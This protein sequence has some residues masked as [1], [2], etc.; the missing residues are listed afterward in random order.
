MKKLLAMILA[1]AMTLT[2][3]TACGKDDSQPDT[4][5]DSSVISGSQQTEPE[6]DTDYNYETLMQIWK[7]DYQ[8]Y[9]ANKDGAYLQ[10]TYDSDNKAV[11]IFYNKEGNPTSYAQA[12]SLMS[13]DKS[14]YR[15]DLYYPEKCEGVR[16]KL[17]QTVGTGIL[18]I[19]RAGEV[20]WVDFPY[21]LLTDSKGNSKAYA[22]AGRDGREIET[23]ME[24]AA[25][26]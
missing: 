9:W 19:E 1:A 25:K 2:V 22:W 10:F 24:N 6:D 15:L 5:S 13:M 26:V 12:T 14:S 11:L 3:F 23:A 16:K 8:G 17:V 21:I 20:D 7:D 18:Y 4:P